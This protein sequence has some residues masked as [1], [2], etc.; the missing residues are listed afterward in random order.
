[1][2]LNGSEWSASNSATLPPGKKS[3]VP[4][5]EGAECAPELVWMRW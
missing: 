3:P 1:L 4:T 5:G 2:V